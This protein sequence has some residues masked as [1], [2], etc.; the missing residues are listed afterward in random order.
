MTVR[1]T[2]DLLA[3]DKRVQRMIRREAEAIE[4]SFP[5][6]TFDIQARIAEEFDQLHG[7]RVRC[8]LVATSPE[9]QQ[10]IVREAHKKPEDAILAA[11]SGLKPKLRRLRLRRFDKDAG[12]TALRPTGT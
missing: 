2:G 9:R 7:H 4:Q 10:V 3:L 8:E 12:E 5:N 1:I 6:R 11:F